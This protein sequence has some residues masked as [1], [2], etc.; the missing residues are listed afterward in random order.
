MDIEDLARQGPAGGIDRRRFL[1]LLGTGASLSALYPILTS[2]GSRST[3]STRKEGQLLRIVVGADPGTLDPIH[4]SNDIGGAMLWE[5]A[6]PL[7]TYFNSDGRLQ[8]KLAKSWKVGP[9]AKSLTFTLREGVRFSDGTPFN[10]QAV[11]FNLDR[12]TDPKLAVS[13][14]LDV[15]NVAGVDVESD[16]AVTVQL[17]QPMS[18]FPYSL[19]YYV[20]A[21]VSPASITKD[22]NSYQKIVA[23]VGTGPYKFVEYVPSS[24]VTLE[25]NENYWGKKPAWKQIRYTIAPDAQAREAAVL[26]GDADIAL[27]PP[28]V[29][30]PRLR[31]GGKTN[32]ITRPG[33]RAVFFGINTAGVN[34]PALRDVRVRRA[35]NYAVDNKTIINKVLFGVA[36]E[37]DA[38]GPKTVPGYVH[39]GTYGYD[40][41]RAKSLLKAAGA[42]NMTLKMA[43]TTGRYLQDIEAAQAV[44]GYLRAVG[45]NVVG[46]DTMSFPTYL[47]TVNVAPEK[48]KY[49][50]ALLGLMSTSMGAQMEFFTSQYVSPAGLNFAGERNPQVDRLVA[51]ANSTSDTAQA[52]RSYG[53]AQK[54]IWNDA[55]WIFLWTENVS[56]LVSKGI[57]GVDLVPYGDA[58]IDASSPRSQ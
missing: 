56:L 23:P 30:L 45:I 10:A 8:P 18:Y 55:P 11:K 13:L 35:L 50:L 46:P 28:P 25:R 57:Q 24:H 41:E 22:G 17:K 36:T 19:A 16:H 44:A 43:S 58:Y 53:D 27:A 32:V 6:E 3:T 12:V 51:S 4:Q 49:D 7:T 31:S 38:P 26:A 54:L 14:L 21:M 33:N 37:L 40:P 5:I 34:Q 52:N 15:A 9:D 1:S 47:A 48:A 39:T 42:D 29:D 20:E 2:C